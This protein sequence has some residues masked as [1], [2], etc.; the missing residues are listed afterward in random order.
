[1]NIQICLQISQQDRDHGEMWKSHVD[2]HSIFTLCY[3][4]DL[5]LSVYSFPEKGLISS[6][7][8]GMQICPNRVIKTVIW[9]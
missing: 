1:M 9:T 6:F 7:P 2:L 4:M 8:E 5:S 3:H